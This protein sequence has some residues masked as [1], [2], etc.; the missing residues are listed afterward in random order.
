MSE[1]LCHIDNRIR[2]H[3]NAGAHSRVR[4]DRLMGSGRYTTGCQ[5]TLLYMCDSFARS[6]MRWWGYRGRWTPAKSGIGGGQEKTGNRE[7]MYDDSS[8]AG[9]CWHS[10]SDR[11]EF[12]DAGM[13]Q[14]TFLLDSLKT[15]TIVTWIKRKKLLTMLLSK[16]MVITTMLSLTIMQSCIQIKRNLQKIMNSTGDNHKIRATL[17]RALF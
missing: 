6:N 7:D 9:E 11:L 10:G 3:L 17:R 4:L 1:R 5:Q 2:C 12:Q 14:F 13:S 8:L 15:R 16:V